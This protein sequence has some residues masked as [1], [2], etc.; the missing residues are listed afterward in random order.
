MERKTAN[1]IRARVRAEMIDEIKAV[2]RRHLATDGANLSLRAI[3][4]DLGVVSSALYRYFAGRDEL[5]TA[6]I[7]DAYNDL[8]EAAERADA[9][10]VDR[11]DFR[12]RWLAVSRAL[13]AWALA[14]PAEYGLL[15]GTPVPGYAAPTDTV[16]PATRTV[17][18]LGRILADA[19]P[20]DGRDFAL[21]P[22]LRAEIQR[23]AVA[24]SSSVED[25]SLVRG[26]IAWT[27]LFG[28]LNFELFGR[29]NNTINERDE[30]FDQQ[31]Y[32][33]V[34]FMGLP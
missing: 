21:S 24:S 34:G 3:A 5:L 2:A 31:M 16:S 22:A 27:L 33:M 17:R 14:N 23:M 4:R 8:G 12:G 1:G 30:W 19:G 10:V 29:I 6:L 25:S 11:A 7:M 28:A 18:V 26:L 32:A 13:R 9:A 20:L 15:Y